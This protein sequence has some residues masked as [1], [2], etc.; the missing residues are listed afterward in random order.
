MTEL[1]ALR[2]EVQQMRAL[3]QVVAQATNR[4][5]DR[6]EMAQRLGIST[7]TLDRRIKDRTVPAPI[8]GRWSLVAV[9][10]WEQSQQRSQV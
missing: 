1:Q 6:H 8:N 9:V 7:S 3:L 4:H 2:T 10:E 5:I